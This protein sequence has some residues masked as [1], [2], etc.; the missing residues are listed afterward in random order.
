[1]RFFSVFLAWLA[2][3]SALNVVLRRWVSTHET[4]KLSAA[5]VRDLVLSPWPWIAALMYVTCAALYAAALALAPL[6]TAGPI[7]LT[8]GVVA[9]SLLG[10]MLFGET[11]SPVTA[12]ALSI[13]CVGICLMALADV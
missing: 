4:V 7:F 3:F 10:W 5:L 13:M 1:V 2:V 9:T 6:S 12:A 11:L 8:A